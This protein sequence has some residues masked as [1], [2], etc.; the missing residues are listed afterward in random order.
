[1]QLTSRITS[2]TPPNTIL[3]I[4]HSPCSR[5]SFSFSRRNGYAKDLP[6][7]VERGSGGGRDVDW[8]LPYCDSKSLARSVSALSGVTMQFQCE[9]KHIQNQAG[10]AHH[11]LVVE[12]QQRA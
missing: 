10:E 9:Q 8:Q 7:W 5:S 3:L 11:A 12:A 4:R 6:F 2:S 1:M